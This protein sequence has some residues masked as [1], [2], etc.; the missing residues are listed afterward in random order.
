MW[1]LVKVCVVA[2]VKEYME[3]EEKRR[4]SGRRGCFLTE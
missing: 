4:G 3:H 1:G 2:V